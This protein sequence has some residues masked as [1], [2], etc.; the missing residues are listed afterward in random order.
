MDPIVIFLI[1]GE[2]N[3]PRDPVVVVNEMREANSRLQFLTIN[4][5]SEPTDKR[6][7]DMADAGGGKFEVVTVNQVELTL[8]FEHLAKTLRLW[9]TTLI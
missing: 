8:V 2:D 1:D 3:D 4:F 9:V 6:L 7:K 5:G